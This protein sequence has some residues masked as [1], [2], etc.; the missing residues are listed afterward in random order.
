[1]SLKRVCPI[2]HMFFILLW[3]AF[4]GCIC[5]RHKKINFGYTPEVIMYR[6]MLLLTFL[7]FILSIDLSAQF[8]SD[9]LNSEYIELQESRFI[10]GG[11]ILTFEDSRIL[12]SGDEG[13]KYE[14]A[15]NAPGA[16]GLFFK[17]KNWPSVKLSFPLNSDIDGGEINSKG[18]K[19]GI[20]INPVQN[21]V[22]DIYYNKLS[23]FNQYNDDDLF[24][25]TVPDMATSNISVNS[26]YIFSAD[27]YSYKHAFSVGQRQ[28]QSAGSWMLGLT[29][30]RTKQDKEQKLINEK[31]V[32][33]QRTDFTDVK[34]A[35]AAIL[36]GYGHNFIFGRNKKGF[37]GFGLFMGPNFHSGTIEYV[38]LDEEQFSGI[39]YTITSIVSGGAKFDNG[40]Q[41]QLK[42]FV[43]D[44]G[45]GIPDAS[46][47]TGLTEAE[48]SIIK[49]IY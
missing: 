26:Y 24:L 18:F 39:D 8:F 48:L 17:Y 23:Q 13:L 6:Y 33:F 14:L 38:E 22:A 47:R 16:I 15:S 40:M 45:Y 5:I 29:L 41:V 46:L 27:K 4:F 10:F 35:Q 25:A 20:H 44:Y 1:M 30:N 42:V 7:I 32:F 31:S 36:F 9:N 2:D 34:A 11:Q 12:E 21:F 19:L 43:S 3:S 37:F 28:L 49:Y